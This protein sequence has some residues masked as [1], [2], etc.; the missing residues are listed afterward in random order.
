MALIA[1]LLLLL[2]ACSTPLPKEAPPLF[3]LEEPLLLFQEPQ[4]ESARK[5]LPAGGFTGITVADARRSLDEQTQ[6]PLGVLVLQV[7]ENS[8]GAAAGVVADDL[9]L[10]VL[11]EGSPPQELR[12]PAEWRQVELGTT[13]GSKLTV[14]LDRAG[15]EHTVTLDVTARLEPAPRGA[16][17]RLREE[18]R[19]GLVVR[20]AT[21]VEA[22]AAS[23]P[24]GA[25]AV[26]VGL[27]RGSPWRAPG[28]RF[29]DLITH[30][31][32]LAV[33]DPQVLLQHIARADSDGHLTLRLV[34][35]GAPQEIEVPVS[36]RAGE[37]T[38]FS[39]PILFSFERERDRKGWSLLLGLLGYESTKAAWGFRFLWFVTISGGDADRLEEVRQ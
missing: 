6:D 23:L 28:V 35:A 27:A 4:D 17:V 15:V 18:S 21:E 7:A 26:V 38:G 12:W 25:G 10:R 22:R 11:R 9:L 32:Q 16:M 34:R 33:S 36:R 2:A 20:T 3:D 24:P 31:D 37:I 13:P 5:A 1:S 19:V 14:V 39:I 30:V 8:P 29:G